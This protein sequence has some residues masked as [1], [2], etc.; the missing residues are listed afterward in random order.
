MAQQLTLNEPNS[1]E[2]NNITQNEENASSSNLI[3]TL[4]GNSTLASGIKKGCNCKK[5]KC[6][7][8]YCEC[9]NLKIACNSSCNCER[10]ENGAYGPFGEMNPANI[11]KK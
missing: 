2:E 5:T 11:E 3:S 8:K 1:S 7:K 6:L 4:N 10:C 9:Y